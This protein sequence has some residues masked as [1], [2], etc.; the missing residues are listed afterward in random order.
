MK[1]PSDTLHLSLSPVT[2]SLQEAEEGKINLPADDPAQI[3]PLMQYLYE[4]EYD[5]KL[6]AS[7]AA[8]FSNKDIF[9][10]RDRLDFHYE[11]PH[12]CSQGC[13][14]MNQRVCQHHLCGVMTCNGTCKDFV[15]RECCPGYHASIK[16]VGEDFKEGDSSQFLLHS[17]MYALAEKY[18]VDGLKELALEKFRWCC[19]VFWYTGDFLPAAR[20]VFD[21]NTPEDDRGLRDLVTFTIA[22]HMEVLS[23]PEIRALCREYN[24]LAADL[25]ELKAGL[26][27]FQVYTPLTSKDNLKSSERGGRK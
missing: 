5:P 17:Q 6:P 27:G 13:L 9:K 12:T 19:A 1:V 22:K 16:A 3:K 11:F 18:Q 20:H 4:A 7:H 21:D 24:D 15:C 14:G 23:K 26:L 25:L 10:P 2:D 8:H